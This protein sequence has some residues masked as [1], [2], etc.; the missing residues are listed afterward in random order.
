MLQTPEDDKNLVR[1]LKMHYVWMFR[2]T[3]EVKNPPRML[4]IYQTYQL[5]TKKSTESTKNV[6]DALAF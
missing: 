2:C 4:R 6:K 1:I 3:K 5:S